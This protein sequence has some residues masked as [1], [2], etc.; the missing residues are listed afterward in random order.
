MV[1]CR[2]SSASCVRVKP[3]KKRDDSC[4]LRSRSA[5]VSNDASDASSSPPPEG[6]LWAGGAGA[7]GTGM[8]WRWVLT[9][10]FHTR[11][12]QGNAPPPS[13]QRARALTATLADGLRVG[14][15]HSRRN[16]QQAAGL[17]VT[18]LSRM[19]GPRRRE[20]L[21]PSQLSAPP[22]VVPPISIPLRPLANP[23]ERPSEEFVEIIKNECARG[24]HRP[25]AARRTACVSRTSAEHVQTNSLLPRTQKA[26][27]SITASAFPASKPCRA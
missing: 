2:A 23:E 26:G 9:S 3:R 25:G 18:A 19:R 11:C 27:C 21:L 1:T 5:A 20:P 22:L 17:F 14:Q 8:P 16:V 4:A 24:G 10:A 13:P 7:Y 12:R 6:G 15:W